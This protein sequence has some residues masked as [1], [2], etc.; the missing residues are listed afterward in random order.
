MTRNRLKIAVVG[1]GVAGIV[2]SYLLQ[3]KHDVTIIEKN[4]Y[5]GGH[6]NT[7][8][9]NISDKKSLRVDTG[10]IVL[11]DK[12]YPNFHRF[13]RDLGVGVR[14]SDM[15]FAH[16][17]DIDGFCYAGTSLDG[18]FADRRNCFRPTFY[19]FIYDILSF[20]RRANK[21]LLANE[22]HGLRL[23]EYLTRL[24]IHS[25]F[26]THYIQPMIAAIWSCSD[27][28]ALDFPA[29][30]LVRFF[31]NHGLLSL[32]DRPRWQ[33]VI[34]GSK[35][36]VEA[37]EKSFKGN[38]W[39]KDGVTSIRRELN[40]I[41]LF[42]ES[43]A[44]HSFDKVVIAAHADHALSILSEPSA[45]EVGCLSPWNYNINRTVLHIDS[46]VLPENQRAWASWNYRSYGSKEEPEFLVTYNMNKLQGLN[47][48]DIYCVTLNPRD[49]I[50]QN[51]VIRSFD[52]EHPQYSLES[53]K[54]QSKLK[55]LNG[56]QHTYFCGSYFGHG[57][58]EDAVSS[59]VEVA[60]LFDI[61][62]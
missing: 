8:T 15:S 1:G 35:S 50:N 18:L 44:E 10:F 19:K 7:V 48:N 52:Y 22:L 2:S 13:L 49:Y 31:K 25:N 42:Q 56:I 26:Y 12:N 61:H 30:M 36:Y 39:L 54:A 24:N 46:S 27:K 9:V 57:F 47:G 62:L 38:I 14:W 32:K 20:C 34:G 41:K 45:L 53:I 33:T 59:A 17:S 16:Y 55:A 3:R 11:N 6:T 29:E 58:H 28:D 43:G 21:D 51:K 23:G 4:D 60:K 5:L 40:G 37:F